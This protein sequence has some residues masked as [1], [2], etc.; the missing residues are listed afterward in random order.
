MQKGIAFYIGP[1]PLSRPKLSFFSNFVRGDPCLSPQAEENFLD[2]KSEE[3]KNFILDWDS[4][5]QGIEP[6]SKRIKN[7]LNLIGRLV[8]VRDGKNWNDTKNGGLKTINLSSYDVN[9]RKWIQRKF[10][11]RQILG[12]KRR[13]KLNDKKITGIT[14]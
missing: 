5:Y 10:K 14:L 6:I 9:G 8:G 13:Q 11:K 1:D 4:T 2:L 7:L 3:V 12:S